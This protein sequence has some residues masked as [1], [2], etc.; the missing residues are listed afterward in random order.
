MDGFAV[1]AADTPGDASGRLPRRGGHPAAGPLA[2]RRRRGHRD[3]RRGSGRARTRSSRSSSST[4]AARRRRDRRSAPY[5]AQHVRPRGGDV[6]AGDVVVAPGTRLGPA[7]IGA[8]AAAGVGE[9]VC[10]SAPARRGA[11]D[12]QRAP[13]R[14]GRARAGQIY[15]SNRAMVAAVLDGA[16]AQ[17]RACCP[18]SPTTPTLTAPRSSAAWTRTCSSRP[19]A[20]LDGRRTTSF[21]ESRPTSACEEVFWGV[22]VKPGKPLSFGVRDAHARLRP[23]REPGVVARRRARLR[24]TGAA[25]APGRAS[26]RPRYARASRATRSGGTRT[27]TSSSARVARDE[28]SGRA[29]AD[30]RTGVAHDRPRG[31]RRRARPRAPRRRRD[32]GRESRPLPRSRLAGP[33]EDTPARPGGGGSRRRRTARSG[34]RRARRAVPPLRPRRVPRTTEPSGTYPTVARPTT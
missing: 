26:P 30:R 4:I 17:R 31:C 5:R 18:S 21:G 19:A 29:R 10:S 2:A 1:R 22:A 3:G 6:R 27:E 28:G 24:P 16:G 33:R 7:Q 14:R 32:R 13:C 23:A 12:G 34:R 25:R 20:C 8:L 11:R 9:V 15:E